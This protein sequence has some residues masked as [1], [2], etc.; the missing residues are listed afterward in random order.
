MIVIVSISK[1]NG[2]IQLGV[3][4]PQHN[5]KPVQIYSS[6]KEARKV[7]LAFGVAPEAADL[8]LFKLFPQLSEDQELAF[9]PMDVPQNELLSRGFKILTEISQV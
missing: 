8:Y 7:L 9:P 2:S 6:E 1:R 3:A 4:K 5:S